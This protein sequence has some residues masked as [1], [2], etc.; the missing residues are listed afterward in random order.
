MGL[1]GC[2]SSFAYPGMGSFEHLDVRPPKRVHCV[3]ETLFGNSGTR[4]VSRID[5]TLRHLGLGLTGVERP[6]L[7][8]ISRLHCH[9]S[10]RFVAQISSESPFLSNL[11]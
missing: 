11:P 2:E 5:P 8:P 9:Y 10:R 4:D 1:S 6:H 7:D 3:V